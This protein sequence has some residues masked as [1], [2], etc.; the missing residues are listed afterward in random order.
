MLLSRLVWRS[1][2]RWAANG[3]LLA[4]ATWSCWSVAGALSPAEW[5]T[6]FGR[7]VLGVVA[8]VALTAFLSA[9]SRSR[10][11]HE[12]DTS[13]WRSLG[14][15]FTGDTGLRPE[16]WVLLVL[17]PLLIAREVNIGWRWQ[18]L[19]FGAAGLSAL[20]RTRPLTRDPAWPIA[21]L[22]I[23]LG[24][25]VSYLACGAR[26]PGSTNND[27][28]YYFGVARHIAETGRLEE[29]LIWHFLL[30][31]GSVV[32]APYDY[33]PA[34]PS[35]WLV[36]VFKL[37]GSQPMVLGLAASSVSCL[38]VLLFWY[39]V[40][41]VWRWSSAAVQ[42]VTLVLFAYSPALRDYRM[43][44]ETVPWTHVFML[45]SLI[46]L[47][48]QRVVLATVLGFFIFL[49]RPDCV[50]L[51]GVVWIFAA[52]LA[53]RR[54][55]VRAYATACAAL[56]GAY[57]LFNA[58]LFG[59]WSPPGA[60]LAPHLID[61]LELYR[62]REAG[63]SLVSL[64][65]RL[66]PQYFEGRANVAFETLRDLK[67]VPWFYFWLPLGIA[68]GARMRRSPNHGALAAWWMLPLGALTPSLISP[69]VFA[70][71][72]TLHPLLPLLLLVAGQ[73]LEELFVRAQ[74]AAKQWRATN[75]LLPG[76]SAG[77]GSAFA[78]LMLYSVK[79]YT[80]PPGLPGQAHAPTALASN[81]DGGVVMS[82]FPWFVLSNTRSPAVC[83]PHNGE[84]AVRQVVERYGVRWLIIP[85][86]G[87]C[88]TETGAWCQQVMA[89]RGGTLG[90]CSLTYVATGADSTLFRVGPTSAGAMSCFSPP[91]ESSP[92]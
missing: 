16:L 18:G 59:S 45:A 82:L 58:A 19:L 61:G 36:P 8:V 44:A 2:G 89:T 31:H 10:S 5:G 63:P 53:K 81:L 76:L 43:E 77:A 6:Q 69:I 67:F 35:I 75:L 51:T 9:Q 48:R 56:L 28:A 40:S 7:V 37:F 41:V 55:E 13:A 17:C 22:A 84:E 65:E 4:S 29:P 26:L 71:W 11:L 23:A 91:A 80:E 38:S 42:L 30:P 32:H 64:F 62:Y 52:L 24:I 83:M 85:T 39:L 72:R 78:V 50:A 3:S 86:N 27:A 73:A 15:A 57:V 54:A 60:R 1:L 90:R 20:G 21:L 14:G 12:S 47:S 68:F 74:T 88:P 49:A 66:G 70:S 92:L 87:D 79:P 33:W 34:W 46:A 25:C